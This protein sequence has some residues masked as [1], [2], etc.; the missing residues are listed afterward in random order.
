MIPLIL[1]NSCLPYNQEAKIPEADD[2]TKQALDKYLNERVILTAGDQEFMGNMKH[3]KR[4]ANGIPVGV[5][6]SNPILDTQQ[7]EVNF[8]D[9]TTPSFP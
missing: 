5:S 1:K 6:E 4:G 3:R 8:N 2:Y 9:V 7:H